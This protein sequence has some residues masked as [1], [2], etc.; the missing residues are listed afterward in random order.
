[1]VD[2][3]IRGLAEWTPAVLAAWPRSTACTCIFDHLPPDVDQNILSLLSRQLERCGPANLTIHSC[4]EPACY[5]VFVLGVVWGVF[6]AGLVAL[7]F[8]GRSSWAA[9]PSRAALSGPP[10][11][12]PLAS[13]TTVVPERSAASLLTPAARGRA[14]LPPGRLALAD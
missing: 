14:R 1:M 7:L 3:V 9:S 10:L 2:R 12:P 13:A 4:P 11:S 6:F 5:A 8:R